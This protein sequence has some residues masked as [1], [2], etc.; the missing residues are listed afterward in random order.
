MPVLLL[1]LGIFFIFNAVCPLSMPLLDPAKIRVMHGLPS[2]GHPNP[3]RE[4]RLREGKNQRKGWWLNERHSIQKK[5]LIREKGIERS[6][7]KIS[8]I[9]VGEREYG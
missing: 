2:Y 8:R 5:T 7:P 3:A 4:L 6:E 1:I 9:T